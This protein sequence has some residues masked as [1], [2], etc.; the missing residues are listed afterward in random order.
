V[1]KGEVAKKDVGFKSLE[2]EG[3]QLHQSMAK[4]WHQGRIWGG[5][6][7]SKGPILVPNTNKGG[8]RGGGMVNK[9][10][11]ST[12]K[13]ADPSPGQGLEA[14]LTAS[15]NDATV[16]KH[17]L[18]KNFGADLLEIVSDLPEDFIGI[19]TGKKVGAKESCVKDKF[20]SYVGKSHWQVSMASC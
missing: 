17:T 3:D 18:W 8:R 10:A 15:R 6:G 5:K 7:P 2:G 13:S 12:R 14:S 9:N 16:V 4:K 11:A 1:K 20:T 19:T